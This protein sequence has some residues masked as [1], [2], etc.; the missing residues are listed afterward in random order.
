M[1][2]QTLSDAPSGVSTSSPDTLSA[3]PDIFPT[4]VE[5]VRQGGEESS[6]SY[7]AFIQSKTHLAGSFGFDP[8]FMPEILFGFQQSLTTWAI[9]K[10][11]GAMFAD[12]GLGKSFM[13]LTWAENVVRKESNPVLLLTPLAVGAQ[14]LIEAEKLGVEAVRSRDGK[15]PPGSRIVIA[16]Y[17]K[18][19]LFDKNDFAGVVCDES[20]IL[21][22]VDGATKAVVTE[23][24]RKMK[25]RLLC[26]ATAAPNDF[27][28]LG[29][30]SEALGDLGYMDML[31]RFFKN[32]Q[33]S[34]HPS[35]YRH[36][37]MDFNRL[38]ESA[39][40]RFRGHSEQ[41][42]WRWVCSWARACRKPSD[43]GF[44][45]DDFKLPD[46]LTHQHVVKARTVNPDF[47][48]DMP[49][50]GLD[51][52]RK[53]RSRT[54]QERC[55]MAA[56]IANS[57]KEPV[58]AWCHLNRESDILEKIMPDAVQVSGGDSDDRKE[59]VFNGFSS[60]D[61]RIIVTKPKI[62]SMGMNWQH[63]SRQ[64]MFPSHSFEQFY[65]AIRRSWRFGQKKNVTVDVITSEG[66]ANVLNNLQRKAEAAEKMFSNLVS[67]MNN[68]LKIESENLHTKPT[69]LPQWL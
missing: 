22:N 50:V 68:E 17:E 14:T 51:E 59:E 64:I 41:D 27:I 29:T 34:M 24:M 16:N 69:T 35:V 33:N 30:S 2:S 52:Q 43:L 48:F 54:C 40:W 61:I 26:T 53:E 10:G 21:K 15:F 46:L 49:A 6:K 38:N 18:L 3:K 8:I 66:E 12:C 65:Q 67:L 1:T 9:R 58:V 55:E 45:D 13:Q 20:S 44:P 5:S 56:E 11:R 31:G 32:A 39:K 37:G 7:Q 62:A 19:H 42:F 57:L 4:S 23:F 25:Y 63:C 36:R 47:L 28:E 60:G